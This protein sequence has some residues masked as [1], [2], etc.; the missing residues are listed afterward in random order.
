MPLV[1]KMTRRRRLMNH[2]YL[3]PHTNVDLRLEAMA[4]FDEWIESR[5]TAVTLIEPREVVIALE[6]RGKRG[7]L[8]SDG[9]DRLIVNEFS[10][11]NVVEQINLWASDSDT[12]S[13]YSAL[14][15]IVSGVASN[16]GEKN[17]LLAAIEN[18]VAAIREGRKCSWR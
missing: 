14:A 4:N 8:R 1:A 13:Y 12:A 18:E 11:Q 6:H 9:L 5:V 7:L 17:V 2:V 3:Q 10:Q 15:E 16:P